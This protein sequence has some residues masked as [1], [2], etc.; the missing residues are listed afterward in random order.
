M[1]LTSNTKTRSMPWSHVRI[2]NLWYDQDTRLEPEKPSLK[3]FED[4]TAW[5]FFLL[6]MNE[7]T[8]CIY[9]LVDFHSSF[10][11][12]NSKV[13]ST[14]KAVL[15]SLFIYRDT[16]VVIRNEQTQH[17]KGY[18]QQI[19]NGILKTMLSKNYKLMSPCDQFY[20]KPTKINYNKEPSTH[21]NHSTNQPS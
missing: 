19:A 20:Q 10:V 3:L 1:S 14:C 21:I 15:Y 4:Y 7:S 2:K 8:D 12:L 17:S 18:Y 11:L 13:G 16:S 6:L 5:C 9:Y